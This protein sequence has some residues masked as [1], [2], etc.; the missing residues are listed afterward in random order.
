MNSVAA[1]ARW[2]SARGHF[3]R[4][5]PVSRPMTSL[6]TMSE[7][8]MQDMEARISSLAQIAVQQA[9]RQALATGGNLVEARDGQLVETAADDTVQVIR[10]ISKPIPVALGA[11]RFSDHGAAQR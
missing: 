1:C 10:H 4:I 6:S 7:A 8:S 5:S 9:R 2:I 11:K 3:D